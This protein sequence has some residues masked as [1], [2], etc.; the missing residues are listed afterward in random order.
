M[1]SLASRPLL[2]LPLNLE[3]TTHPGPFHILSQA[4]QSC[5]CCLMGRDLL[6]DVSCLK[7]CPTDACLVQESREPRNQPPCQRWG[8]QNRGGSLLPRKRWAWWR[9]TG[10]GASSRFQSRLCSVCSSSAA[11]RVGLFPPGGCSGC[12]N[13]SHLLTA[14]CTPGTFSSSHSLHCSPF[15]NTAR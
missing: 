4:Q 3:S 1:L 6:M 12:P 5:I 9:S 15:P 8:A 11:I 13:T 7:P 10:L 2:G 14:Y